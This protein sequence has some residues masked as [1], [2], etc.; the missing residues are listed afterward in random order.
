MSGLVASVVVPTYDRP[1]RLRECLES[2]AR[3]T[4]AAPWEV[5]VIDDGTPDA[6]AVAAAVGTGRPGWRVIRQDNAGPAAARN[7]GV[8]EARGEFIAFTDDDCLPEPAW[9]ETLVQA[10]RARPDALVGGTTVNGLEDELFAST[11]QLIVDMVYE[12]FN[13]DPDDAYFLTSNNMLCQRERFQAMG[14]FDA[15]F[16]RAGAEDREFCDRWRMAGWPIV[17]RPEARIEHRHSQTLRQFVG[18]HLRYGRGAKIYHAMRHQRGSG[19]MQ[20]DLGFHRSLLRRVAAR[21]ADQ[22]G[23]CRR[24]QVVAAL[25]IWQVANAAGFATEGIASPRRSR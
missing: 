22:G 6:Q 9:L 25:V 16:P 3:Q 1:R 11:S 24:A 8:R 17:W 12:H 10:A 18:L 15:A 4:L 5:L 14:G 21:L 7:R 19:T 2:L 20:K 23:I 13:S